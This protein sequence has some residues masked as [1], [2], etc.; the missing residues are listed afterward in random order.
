[1]TTS[2]LILPAPLP[3]S[4]RWRTTLPTL[5]ALLFWV[6]FLYRNTAVAMV[7][8]W[9]RS[10]TFTHGFL[11]VPIVVWLIWRKR[12][13]L[14][15]DN[16]QP[17]PRMM[18]IAAL[19]A[20]AWFLGEMAV[21]QALT[22]FALVALLVASVAALLGRRVSKQILFPLGFLFFAVPA[23]E[24]LL[25]YFM[26]WTAN[27]TVFALRLSGIPVYREGL[28]FVIPS[29]S[30]SVIEACSG[31]RYLIA[32]LMVG[33]L[34]AYLNYQSNQRRVIFVAVSI[35]VP[36]VANWVRA[37]MIVMLGHLSGN[38]LAVGVDHLIYGWI[39]FGIVIMLMF[40][41]GNRWAEPDPIGVRDDAPSDRS[42]A[43]S[44]SLG[45][46]S[47][48]VC[49]ALIAA[50]PHM[51]L[52]TIDRN[53]DTGSV[54]LTAPTTLASPWQT[55][56]VG[57]AD[58]KPAFQ[59]PSSATNTAYTSAQGAV[60]LYLGYY[61]HQDYVHKMVSSENVLVV[62]Q[63]PHWLRVANA[64]KEVPIAGKQVAVR[65]AKLRASA[66]A[67][68]PDKYLVVWQFYWING[69]VTANDYLAKAYGILNRL[70][71]LGD[72]A[73]VIVVYTP[74]ES[75]QDA[76][77]VLASFLSSNYV[78]INEALVKTRQNR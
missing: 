24:F 39:F 59:N 71:G 19:A 69:K 66:L 46:G 32:S 41:V 31:V 77:S 12:Q 52:S 5:F 60:G 20:F 34:F 44:G 55:T 27:F 15:K 40:I 74:Q 25:P 1:M 9:S 14:A 72:D 6:L 50:L 36:V 70:T 62:S 53:S 76:D 63:D 78:F 10:E 43:A 38:K 35:V 47:V 54:H 30:W 49:L 67:Q 56:S 37:Y 2:A 57:V 42:V 7:A 8:I 45:L 21:T 51:A 26:E 73:A 18:V 48:A 58:F 64:S 61:R 17:E 68:G 29:G 65:T 16:P 28:N 22:Q 11:V 13:E 3:W 33:T 4:Q 23:G 75:T